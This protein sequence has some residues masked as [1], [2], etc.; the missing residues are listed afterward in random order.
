MIFFGSEDGIWVFWELVQF[1]DVLFDYGDVVVDDFNQ[2]GYFDIVFV[3]YLMGVVV[4]VGDG[5]GC[6][7]QWGEGLLIFQMKMRFLGK[8]KWVVSFFMFRVIVVI[9]W[10]GDGCFDFL[11]LVEGLSSFEV[12]VEGNS[13]FK[14]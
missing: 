13:G 10:I 8:E 4:M 3:I 11:V 2:D 9:D 1:D 6:F 7:C 5:E 14:G 12:I